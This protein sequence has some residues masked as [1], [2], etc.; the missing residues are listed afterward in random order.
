MFYGGGNCTLG[1]GRC[2]EDRLIN[3]KFS[4]SES[5]VFGLSWGCGNDRVERHDHDWNNGDRPQTAPPRELR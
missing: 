2:Y 1:L 4:V 3:G 5:Q